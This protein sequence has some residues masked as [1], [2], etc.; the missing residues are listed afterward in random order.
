MPGFI[1]RRNDRISEAV[2]SGPV[3]LRI[4]L[5]ISPQI[6]RQGIL[7]RHF[8][9]FGKKTPSIFSCI[10][11]PQ[12][13]NDITGNFRTLCHAAVPTVKQTRRKSADAGMAADQ[14][15]LDRFISSSS[16][17]TESCMGSRSQAGYRPTAS[18]KKAKMPRT[19]SSRTSMSFRPATA[20]F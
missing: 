2:A 6:V 5:Q 14:G 15:I 17:V 12:H 10:F 16:S 13:S 8:A 1:R 19:Q 3:F 18:T 9:F 4:S 11:I 20:S 7:V